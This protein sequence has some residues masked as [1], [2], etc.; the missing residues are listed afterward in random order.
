LKKGGER[1][2]RVEI[3][4]GPPGHAGAGMNIDVKTDAVKIRVEKHRK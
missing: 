4:A 1:D 2:K 3:G